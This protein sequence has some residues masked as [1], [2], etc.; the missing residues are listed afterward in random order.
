MY[1]PTYPKLRSNWPSGSE[2]GEGFKEKMGLHQNLRDVE[3]IFRVHR[4]VVDVLE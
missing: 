2:G 1:I 4:F 3:R